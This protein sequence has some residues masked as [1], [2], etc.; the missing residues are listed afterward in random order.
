M[1][2]KVQSE[3][4]P[5]LK[6]FLSL[7]VLVRCIQNFPPDGSMKKSVR[8]PG[9]WDPQRFSQTYFC[10]VWYSEVEQVMPVCFSR[11]QPGFGET[12]DITVADI[13]LETDTA[14]GVIQFIIQPLYIW[15]AGC[16][17]EKCVAVILSRVQSLCCLG[18]FD[19]CRDGLACLCGHDHS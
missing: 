2:F 10:S 8:Y 18:C 9:G 15:Q 6:L 19:G 4:V 7:S 5:V 16:L 1:Y 13:T 14:M 11:I 3:V 17:A 12:K